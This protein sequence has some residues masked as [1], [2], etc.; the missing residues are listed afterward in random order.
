MNTPG[1]ETGKHSNVKPEEPESITGM[2]GESNNI[3]LPEEKPVTREPME[4][5]VRLER[6]NFEKAPLKRLS[7]TIAK[8]LQNEMKNVTAVVN[9]DAGDSDDK[10]PE[11]ESCKN[12][13]C[14]EVDVN[15][16][17]MNHDFFLSFLMFFRRTKERRANLVSVSTIPE[18]LSFTKE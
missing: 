10:I 13:G 5:R 17:M 3:D 7:P 16:C 9:N 15:S 2:V 18:S 12:G 1:C 11:G 4:A 8:S 6:P 14:K